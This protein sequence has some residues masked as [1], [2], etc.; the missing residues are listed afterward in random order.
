MPI[1][2]RPPKLRLTSGAAVV[3][4]VEVVVGQLPILTPSRVTLAGQLG[5][6]RVTDTAGVVVCGASTFGTLA[7]IPLPGLAVTVTLLEVL[8]PLEDAGG[9]V[10]VV[11]LPPGGWVVGE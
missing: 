4:G 11:E 10:V 9:T 7:L 3:D 2:Y 8:V 1:S 5:A 6:S